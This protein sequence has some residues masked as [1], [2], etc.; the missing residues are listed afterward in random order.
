LAA[1]SLEER[2][3]T[4]ASQVTRL[5]E[6]ILEL[7]S[8]IVQ[9]RKETQELR[10]QLSTIES[11]DASGSGS[12]ADAEEL[13]PASSRGAMPQQGTTSNATPAARLTE[14]EENQRLLSDRLDEQHQLKV[15]STSRY[16]V[17]LSG[18]NG[19]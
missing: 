18:K 4:L 19:R 3:D 2:I 8:E 5:N 11:P 15:E 1:Q 17:K 6:V 9:S 13:P 10:R 14:I 16:R 12:F 7:R